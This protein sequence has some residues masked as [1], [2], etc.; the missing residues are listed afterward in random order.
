MRHTTQPDR[1]GWTL[2]LILLASWTLR[3]IDLG[4]ASLWID[5]KLVEMWRHQSPADAYSSILSFG[6]EMPLHALLLRLVPVEDR[7]AFGHYRRSHDVDCAAAGW[8]VMNSPGT[9][10]GK[11][12]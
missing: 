10:I 3:L 6:T 7:F 1:P 9:K 2:V 11:L 8:L 12:S 4:W 5:E